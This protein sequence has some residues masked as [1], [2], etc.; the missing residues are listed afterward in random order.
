MDIREFTRHLAE[1]VCDYDD[2]AVRA[3]QLVSLV[4]GLN[5]CDGPG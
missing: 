1:V 2:N 3:L 5:S 4:A